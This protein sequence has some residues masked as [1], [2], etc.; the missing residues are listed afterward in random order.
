[1]NPSCVVF[2]STN[3]MR[4]NPVFDVFWNSSQLACE[5]YMTRIS[6]VSRRE[7]DVFEYNVAVE[8]LTIGSVSDSENES[9]DV[10]IHLIK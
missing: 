8:I 4:M 3:G 10:G 1:M 6:F 7:L 9:I 2:I 5:L